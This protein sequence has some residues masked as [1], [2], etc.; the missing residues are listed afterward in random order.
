MSEHSKKWNFRVPL[1]KKK[2][3]KEKKEKKK[4]NSIST[5]HFYIFFP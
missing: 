3:K 2:E 4:E 1:K 5:L